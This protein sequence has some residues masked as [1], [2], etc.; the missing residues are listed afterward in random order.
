MLC[1]YF[2]AFSQAPD[3][4]FYDINWNL[5]DPESAVFYRVAYVDREKL[6]FNGP[7]QDF[8]LQNRQLIMEGNYVAGKKEGVFNFYALNGELEGTGVYENNRRSGQWNYYYPGRRIHKEIIFINQNRTY[9]ISLHSLYDST[10]RQL[11]TQGNGYWQDFDRNTANNKPI[12]LYGKVINGKKDDMWV[13]QYQNGEKILQEYHA[14]GI[15]KF[16]DTWDKGKKFSYYG[17]RINFI[18]PSELIKTELFLYDTELFDKAYYGE[19][20]DY[21]LYKY[22]HIQHQMLAS[23]NNYRKVNRIA[24]SCNEEKYEPANYEGGPLELYRYVQA[25]TKQS[26]ESGYRNGKIII[27]FTVNQHGKVQNYFVSKGLTAAQNS[28][29]IEIV[30]KID[31]I[32]ATCNGKAVKSYLRIAIN[33]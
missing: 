13:L 18:E 22:L 8:F 14:G 3:T 25:A 23:D 15:F 30:K 28:N 11:V 32:P 19:G 7:V 10:G 20:L 12:V 27:N 21:F 4:L 1:L 9:D 24:T 2:P 16:G 31:W 6:L 5:T 17:S 29:A 33:Y 26:I